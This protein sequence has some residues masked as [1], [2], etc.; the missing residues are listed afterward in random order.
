MES[1]AQPVP[2]N[3]GVNPG[4]LLLR[5]ASNAGRARGPARS[6]RRLNHGHAG[7]LA[8]DTF[9]MVPVT[10]I[11]PGGAFHFSGKCQAFRRDDRRIVK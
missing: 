4:E 11:C 3:L 9:P 6:A 8:T 1:T 10:L 7:D 2:T 5:A